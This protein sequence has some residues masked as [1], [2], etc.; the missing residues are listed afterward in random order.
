MA[1]FGLWAGG[2]TEA[3]LTAFT[4]AFQVSFPILLGAWDVFFDHRQGGGTSPF[5]LDY[6]IDQAGRV[7]Y[8][9][10]E[11]DPEAMVATIDELLAG[12]T[13]VDDPPRLLPLRVVARPNPF[14]PRTEVIFWLPHDD[15]VSLDIHDTRGHLVRRLVQDEFYPGGENAVLWDGADNGGRALPAG[16]YLARVRTGQTSVTGKLTLVR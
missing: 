5:P 10:T 9:N 2:G 6:I 11:Y 4:G 15:Q 1:V 12:T 3:D 8:F 7:A 16:L 14:N 13:S